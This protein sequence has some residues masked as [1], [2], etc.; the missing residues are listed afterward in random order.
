MIVGY[1][2]DSLKR[3]KVSPNMIDEVLCSTMFSHLHLE[4]A[5]HT[6][7]MIVGYTLS[8]RLIEIGVRYLSSESIYIFHAQ[9]VSPQYYELFKQEWDNG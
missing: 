8:E 4:D 7:E 5:E 1:N 2:W 3:H 6:C 9:N